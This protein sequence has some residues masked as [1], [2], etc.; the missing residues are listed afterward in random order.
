MTKR[1]K[2]VSGTNNKHR[3]LHLDTPKIPVEKGE[4]V[5]QVSGIPMLK[6]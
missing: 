6:N 4:K 3:N 1:E 5:V 2:K